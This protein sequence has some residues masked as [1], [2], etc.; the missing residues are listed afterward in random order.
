MKSLYTSLLCCIAL[1]LTFSCTSTETVA[2]LKNCTT[3]TKSN[4]VMRPGE[5]C[6]AIHANLANYAVIGQIWG[7]PSKFW[8]QHS[9]IKVK[10]FYGTNIKK[11]ETWERFKT[12][13]SLTNIKFERVEEG[14]SDIRVAFAPQEGHWS[15][16]GTDNLHIPQSKKTM[17]IGLDDNDS[18]LEYDRVCL[19]EI[20]HA[21]G[22]M[23]ELQSKNVTIN[24]DVP[25]VIAYYK[26]TQGWD[27]AQTRSQVLDYYNGTDF[28]GTEFDPNSIMCY[29]VPP[30][31]TLDGLAIGWN[32]K[33]TKCDEKFIR[34][35]YPK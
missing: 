34:S 28:H 6:T 1:F 13:Q 24:W 10:F 19:H 11:Y 20:L 12:I 23:H 30:E 9:T 18:S 17:N 15:Y 35:V 7:M 14:N 2:P 16:I 5:T 3:Y 8:P 26:K 4:A 22:F 25:K 29:P 21:L 27:E 33:I 31:L 32:Y